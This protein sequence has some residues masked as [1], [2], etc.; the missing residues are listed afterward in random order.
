MR[1]YRGVYRESILGSYIAVS[2]YFLYKHVDWGL[3]IDSILGMEMGGYRGVYVDSILSM[4][5]EGSYY[6]LYKDVESVKQI[7]ILSVFW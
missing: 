4:Y 7:T 5:I 3:Y 2:K 1:V 6:F